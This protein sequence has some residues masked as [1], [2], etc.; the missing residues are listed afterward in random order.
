METIGISIIAYNEEKNIEAA[1]KSALPA[2]QVVLVDCESHDKT[3]EI[4]RKFT[5]LRIFSRPNNANLNI[6]KSFGFSNLSTDWIFYLDPDEIIP[7]KLWLEI[8]EMLAGNKPNEYSAFKIPRLNYYFG[9]PLHHGSMYPDFQTRLFRNGKANFPNRHVH[10]SLKVDGKIGK[11]NNH[12]EHHPYPDVSTYIKKL[13]FYTSF[14]ASFWESENIPRNFFSG[15]FYLLL[16]P[17]SRFFRRYIIKRGFLDGWQG[18]AAAAGDV[19]SNSFSYL[20][21]LELSER[22]YHK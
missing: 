10:E 4:A 1:L 12:F 6:N 14:Q 2:D 8:K 16:K 3:M 7:E 18:F 21:Y 15:I 17:A 9:Q 22:K 20:K 19:F 13:D 5:N 11:I